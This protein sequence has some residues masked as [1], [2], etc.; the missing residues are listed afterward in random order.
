MPSVWSKHLL[1]IRE[2]L[3]S[4]TRQRYPVR[5]QLPMM[6]VIVHGFT[7]TGCSSHRG[8]QLFS[9]IA[10]T[11]AAVVATTDADAVAADVM[12][13]RQQHGE[14]VQLREILRLL[15]VACSSQRGADMPAAPRVVPSTIRRNPGV[16]RACLH[17]CVQGVKFTPW[18]SRI[19]QNFLPMC[20]CS[21]ATPFDH[22]PC[23]QASARVGPAGRGQLW[24]CC[25]RRCCTSIYLCSYL[26]I[27]VVTPWGP[28]M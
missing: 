15:A 8:C 2:L 7:C 12:M 22:G 16:Q 5:Q 17:L 28:H 18:S 27:Y 19:T 23:L 21:D 3:H 24:H 1:V 20:V 14:R 6:H 9:F 4:R 26:S 25:C 13:A 10:A 11:A